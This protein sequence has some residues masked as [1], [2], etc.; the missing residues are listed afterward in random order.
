MANAQGANDFKYSALCRTCFYFMMFYAPQVGNPDAML[1]D[2]AIL[3]MARLAAVAPPV[4]LARQ[5]AAHTLFWYVMLRAARLHGYRL[6]LVD[7]ER[8]IRCPPEELRALLRAALPLG[9]RAGAVADYILGTRRSS[10]WL[11]EE[12]RRY[13]VAEGHAEA[14]AYAARMLEAIRHIDPET[15]VSLLD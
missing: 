10:A 9:I 5:A 13:V 1:R 2:R 4:P 8:L 6:P 12:E 14:E 11:A 7:Y 3:A 15:D